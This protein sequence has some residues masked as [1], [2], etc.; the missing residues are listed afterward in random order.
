MNV[1]F[2]TAIELNVGLGS[3]VNNGLSVKSILA[4]IDLKDELQK[5][6]E[7]YNKALSDIMEHYGVKNIMGKYSWQGNYKQDEIASKIEELVNSEVEL[8]KS[9]CLPEDE[10]IKLTS[11]LSIDAISSLLRFLKK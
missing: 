4:V 6:A 11:G 3:C 7:K 1:T 8:T 9:N 2:K 10:V 5:I